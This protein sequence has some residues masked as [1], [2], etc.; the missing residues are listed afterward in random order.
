MLCNNHKLVFN[1]LI[2]EIEGSFL[3][4]TISKYNSNFRTQHFDTKSHL[5]ALLY[6]NFIN[7]KSL[8]ELQIQ[9]SHNN[10]LKRIINV[11]SVSQFSRKN[12]SRDS[13]IFEDIFYYL[14]SKAKKQFGEYN[15]IKDFPPLRIIDSSVIVTALKLAPSL[16]F[17]NEKSVMKISTLFN[18]EYPERINIVK[19]KVNDKKCI[20]NMFIDKE[21]IYVFDRGYCNYHLYDNLT[22]NGYKFITR[23]MKNSIVME[24]NLRESNINKDI[25][26]TEV[27]LGS[28]P[29]GNL[30]FKSYREIMCFDENDEQITFITNIFY[31]SKEDIINIYKYRWEIELF[32]KWI[33]QNLRI[34][35]FIGFNENAV[36]IQI[37]SALITYMLIYLFC[38]RE[39]SEV[40][41]NML[42]L[43]RII[44]SNLLEIYYEGVINLSG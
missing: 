36:K 40:K 32:F 33:K 28:K 41:Y 35:K 17:D 34:K 24:E 29:G 20:D 38:K 14:V 31:L 4:R 3:K 44:R 8:R 43:T 6:S 15:L 16:K 18:G 25:Y 26:D 39:N 42:I 23:G 9:I 30:T 11:P 7:C 5:Y 37:F 27:I 13:R 22:E 12:A 1:K 21:C 19:G 10:K 2:A